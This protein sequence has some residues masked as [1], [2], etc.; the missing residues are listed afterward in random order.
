M[1]I[2]EQ[3][4]NCS[5]EESVVEKMDTHALAE[6]VLSYPFLMDI[7]MYGNSVDEGILKVGK[8]WPPLRALMQRED[9][10]ETLETLENDALYQEKQLII[11][12]LKNYIKKDEGTDSTSTLSKQDFSN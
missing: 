11:K 7:Y 6:T 9:A 4:K 8:R 2:A 5:I 3:R 10:Y 1:S 12:R